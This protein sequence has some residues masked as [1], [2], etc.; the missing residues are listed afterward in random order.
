MFERHSQISISRIFRTSIKSISGRERADQFGLRPRIIRER[1]SENT[2][3]PTKNKGKQNL[4]ISLDRQTIQKAKIIAARRS[5]SIS[6]LITRQIEI[7]VGEEGYYEQ[8]K[9]QAMTLL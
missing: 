2:M 9:R 7:L 1:W 6:D 4:T 3:A 5:T 8:A